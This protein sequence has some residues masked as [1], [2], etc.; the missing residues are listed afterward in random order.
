MLELYVWNIE[1]E[2]DAVHFTEQAYPHFIKYMG[3]KS[4]IMQFV[5]DGLNE[6]YEGG[7][8]CDLFAGSASLAGAIGRQVS[9]H[10]NDIQSYSSVLAQT[11]LDAYVYGGMPSADEI[12]SQAEGIA[13]EQYEQLRINVDYQSCDSI[14]KFNELERIQ[15]RLIERAFSGEWYLFTKYYSGTWWSAEQCVWIDAVRQIAESY[16]HQPCYPLIISTLM[17]AMAYTSQGTGHYAQYRDAK[18][19]SSMNDISIYR[20]RSLSYYFRKK[21]ESVAAELGVEENPHTHKVTS[22]DYRECLRKFSGGTVYADPPYC[23]VHY[24]R[25]YHAIETLVLYDY[26]VLQNQNGSVVKGRYREG[27]HQSPFCIRT[28]V[29]DAFAEMFA[30]VGATGSNLVLSYSNT[31]MITV[32]EVH[33][34][35]RQYF[36]ERKIELLLTNHQHM[37]L[38]RQFDRHRDVQECLFLVK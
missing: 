36:P 4:K 7:T 6:V 12:L 5:L 20:N 8:V 33:E 17:Y 32:D 27:R 34:L 21:Y 28:Q 9:F 2:S 14:E 29:R 15:Q 1:Q 24:S 35:A 11:Y 31:G 10:S 3:S 38:G 19:Q 13:L 30:G 26:P 22:L 25:F 37:T 18:T 23:F 16:K